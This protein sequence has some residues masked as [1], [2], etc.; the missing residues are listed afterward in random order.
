MAADSLQVIIVAAF[1]LLGED[2][3]TK[4]RD[5]TALFGPGIG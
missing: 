1:Q 2:S 3:E 4:I 5:E